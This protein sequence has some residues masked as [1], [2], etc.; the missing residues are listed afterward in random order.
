MDVSTAPAGPGTTDASHHPDNQLA[1]LQFARAAEARVRRRATVP[2][3]V[4]T[5]ILR[6]TGSEDD[7]DFPGYITQWKE[8]GRRIW[9]NTLLPGPDTLAPGDVWTKIRELFPEDLHRCGWIGCGA[10]FIRL[11][12]HVQTVHLGLKLVCTDCGHAGRPG[13]RHELAAHESNCPRIV[14]GM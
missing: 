14:V 2:P 8:S 1:A 3:H 4:R 12:R 13:E 6:V 7:T 5:K 11:R 9:R 10:S